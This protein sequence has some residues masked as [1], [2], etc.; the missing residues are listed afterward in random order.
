MTDQGPTAEQPIAAW[1]DAVA[2]G[3]PTPGGGAFAAVT[4][5]GGAALISMVCGLTLGREKYAEA[6]PRMRQILDGCEAARREFLDLADADADA[7]E[8]VMAA[9]R[10]PKDTDQEVA[11]RIQALQPALE[12]AA[13]VPHTV[14]R[15]AVEVMGLAAEATAKG[16][17][18]AASD[19]LTGAA[20]LFAS[21]LAALANVQINAISLEDPSRRD[22]L[23]ADCTRLRDRAQALL[24]DAQAAFEAQVAG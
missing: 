4:A 9:Y 20:A 8:G 13:E 18:N 6:E 21:V 10:M 24:A 5:A 11:A 7:F 3:D 22:E 2:S 19:G 12:R 15:R 14:A 17:P 23:T 16:N 1:L